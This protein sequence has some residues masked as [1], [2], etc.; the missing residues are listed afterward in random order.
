[1]RL[2]RLDRFD[3]LSDLRFVVTEPAEVTISANHHSQST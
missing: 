3:R 2:V 1:M